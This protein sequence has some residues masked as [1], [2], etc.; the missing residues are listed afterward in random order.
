MIINHNF[1]EIPDKVPTI[2]GGTYDLKVTSVTEM[3]IKDAPGKKKLVF[4]HEINMDNNPFDGRK[5]KDHIGLDN[6]FSLT[7]LKN[8]YHSATGSRPGKDG[9]DANDLIGRKL[10]AIISVT[11]TKDK[12]GN[13]T[14]YA[15][16]QKYIPPAE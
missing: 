9:F 3:D 15:N 7:K 8:L 16:I 2:E 10:K 5:I 11:A 13:V 4:E 14:E 12:D 1:E 6:A